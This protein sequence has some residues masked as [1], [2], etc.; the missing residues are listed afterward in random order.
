MG[1]GAAAACPGST[2]SL[3][4]VLPKWWRLVTIWFTGEARWVARGYAAAVICLALVTTLFSV[5]ISYAQRDFSTALSGKDVPGFYAA[6]RKFVVIIFIA[7]PLFSFTS[8]VEERLVLSW[9]AHLTRLLTRKYFAHRAFY[10]IRQRG[11]ALDGSSAT[12]AGGSSGGV[13]GSSSAGIGSSSAGSGGAAGGIDNPDQRICDD[14]ASFVRSS[15]SLS[16][17]I[18]RKIFSCV[19][20]AGVLW[21]VSGSLVVFMFM[22]A[23]VGTF[24]TTAMFG[25]VLTSLYYRQLAR[26]ADL[27][28][29]LV[30]VRENAE[31]IAFYKGEAGERVRV[32][33][34]LGGVLGVAYERVRWSALYDLWT[35]VYSYATILVP[36]LLTAP[37]YF[38][39]EIEFGVISQASF[40]FSRIDAALSIII[41]NLAQISG[42]AAETERLHDLVAAMDAAAAAA[43]ATGLPSSG[44]EG[45]GSAAA[46][47]AAAS[48]AAVALLSTAGGGE[49][50][51]RRAA[52]GL[53]GLVL[54]QLRVVTPGGGGGGG[55][56]VLTA[57]LSLSLEPG[58]SL[59]I[60]GPSGCG[61]SS[62]LRAIA[63]LW[64]AGGGTVL[65]PGGPANTAATADDEA[66]AAAAG[67]NNNNSSGSASSASSGSG[68]GGVFFLPQKPFMPLGDLR[69]QLTFPSGVDMAAVTAVAVED[70]T[71]PAG[72]APP[73]TTTTTTRPAA[74]GSQGQGQGEEGDEERAPLL[75][76][77]VTT[78]AAAA[79]AGGGGGGGGGHMA[80]SISL[81]ALQSGAGG[82]GGGSGG[83][84][85]VSDEELLALLDDVCLPDL[86]ARVG[87]L[88]VELD[89]SSVLSVGE[90]QRL[91]V[92]RLLAARPCLAFMD[93]ATSAL[94]GPT[95]SRLY[96]LIRK[97]VPCY[98]SVGHRLALLQHHTHVLEC[99]SGDGAGGGGEGQWR[100]CTAAEYQRRAGAG[101]GGGG[102]AQQHHHH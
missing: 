7:A 71:A 61:K 90:Q 26:E 94:D 80:A 93:E 49:V 66:A 34:R 28:F 81:V 48:A 21:G 3:S 68:G 45:G 75:L 47:A 57:G 9:R 92:L 8:W 13:G 15:V 46:A 88:D 14:V 101:G 76:S 30:R 63:G 54:R 78:T 18:C 97:R 19:A 37:R 89:W 69:T 52:A 23:G 41:N 56:R 29:S 77:H 11:D 64:V 62:L 24:V 98:V 10:H 59:L 55:S 72:A 84:G 22:Y 44:S 70:G 87:G 67:A 42:L 74:P 27:R 1:A 5:H 43:A 2:A 50:I 86:V 96:S 35:S 95:E 65:L 25:R 33:S 83:G 36:S 17:T 32:L 53:R 79:A 12:A 85:S 99:L 38:K 20:F 40:A 73:A 100:V 58:Q 6:V 91:A 51:A 60:V 102:G 16:L 4:S 82:G 39:G 31:S